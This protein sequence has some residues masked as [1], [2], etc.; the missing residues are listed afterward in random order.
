MADVL[1]IERREY[2]YLLHE[3]EVAEVRRLIRPYCSLDPFSAAQE[4]KRYTIE[5]LYFDTH[6]MALFY[7]NDLEKLHRYKL[8]LRRYPDQVLKKKEDE[9][10]FLE[11]KERHHDTIV[12][13]RTPIGHDWAEL[14]Q[15]PFSDLQALHPLSRRFLVNFYS[16]SAQPTA[17]VRYKRE[18]W[19]S[20]VDDYARVTFD[21]HISG[22]L[23]DPT[24][25]AFPKDHFSYRICDDPVGVRS[26]DSFTV[27]E[28]KFT[29]FVPSWMVSLV[30]QLDL[31]RHSY[32]KYGRTIESWLAKNTKRIPAW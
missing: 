31:I 26:A 22:F 6:D 11:L 14:L 23:C 10:F 3:Q 18:A 25:W 21:T 2:K 24:E 7:M 15:N 30:E 27:L 20:Q 19:V 9:L 4:D 5:S 8:R 17:V 29:T 28:L 1:D 32:S 16:L 13:T 12:K